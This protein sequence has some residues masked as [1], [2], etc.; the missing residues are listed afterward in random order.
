[1]STLTSKGQVTIPK[2]VR[3]LLGLEPGAKVDFEVDQ[4]GRVFIARRTK[5]ASKESVFQRLRGSAKGAMTT[6]E[7]MTLTRTAGVDQ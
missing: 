1:M 7:I 3:E 6:D 4:N 2:P 5:A